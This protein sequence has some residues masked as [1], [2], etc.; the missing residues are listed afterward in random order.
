MHHLAISH[1]PVGSDVTI[2][3]SLPVASDSLSIAIASDII[4]VIIVSLSCVGRKT[5]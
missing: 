2:I 3:K 5:C 4:A 1:Q